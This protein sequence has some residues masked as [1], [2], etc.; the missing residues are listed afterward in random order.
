MTAFESCNIHDGA[1]PEA[2][3][4]W[5]D[6]YYAGVLD[7]TLEE[8]AGLSSDELVGELTKRAIAQASIER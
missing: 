6:T 8:E 4:A 1:D 3:L 2:T 7:E 5:A